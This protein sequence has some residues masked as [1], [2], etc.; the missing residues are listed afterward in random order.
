VAA[1]LCISEWDFSNALHKIKEAAGL[2]GADRVIIWSDGTISEDRGDLIG[3]V[4]DE[5]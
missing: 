3:N 5:L 2:G 1:R 4:Y